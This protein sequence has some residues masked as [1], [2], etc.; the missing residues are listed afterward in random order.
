[1]LHITRMQ[2]K[3]VLICSLVVTVA[4]LG[5]ILHNNNGSEEDELYARRAVFGFTN[6]APNAY[7]RPG[8]GAYMYSPPRVFAAP[9]SGRAILT[10]AHQHTIG[11]MVPMKDLNKLEEVQEENSNDIKL[12]RKEERG[13]K[14]E[15]RKTLEKT[16]K[17]LGALMRKMTALIRTNVMLRCI[18]ISSFLHM[19]VAQ[20]FQAHD[21]FLLSH[22]ET[23]SAG[24]QGCWPTWTG[25]QSYPSIWT[26]LY[27]QC[28][29]LSSKGTR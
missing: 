21:I 26:F 8:G 1:M 9:A 27:E 19:Q 15:D 28:K 4:A 20:K 13:L 25:C 22:Q 29:S 6:A 14:E 18:S 23:N 12:L 11:V 3:Y 16:G 2:K 24:S 5:I 7:T 17:Q 10:S